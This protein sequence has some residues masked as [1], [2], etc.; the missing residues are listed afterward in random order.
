[1]AKK[2]LLLALALV[3]V[4][5]A[6]SCGD[7]DDSGGGPAPT[8]GSDQSTTTAQDEGEPVQGG[9]AMLLFWAEQASLDPVRSN[10][11]S[12]STGL[13][14]F[15]LYGALVATDPETL[16]VENVLAES[17]EPN[18]TFDTWTLKIRS[19]V[20]FSD[21]STYNA[22]AVRAHWARIQVPENRSSA[23]AF[24]STVASA[25]PVDELTLEIKL[26]EPNSLFDRL[27]ARS[28]MNYIPSAEA[29]ASGHDLTSDP[30]GAGPFLLDS[31]IRDDRMVLVRNPDWYDA[32]RPYLDKITIRVVTDEE[33]RL[34]TLLTGDAD[35]NYT[36]VAGSVARA[37][38][39][40]AQYEGVEVAFGSTINFNVTK[41]PFDDPELRRAIV[42]AVDR[43][44]MIEAA[45]G[46][47]A[48]APDNF[49]I[50]GTPWYNPDATVPEYDPEQAQQIINDYLARTGQSEINVRMVTTQ[51]PR[52]IALGKFM[53]TSLDQLEGVNIQPEPGDQPTLLQKVFSLD[54]GLASWGFPTLLPDPDLYQGIS[55]TSSA[56]ATGYKSPEVDQL[57]VDARSTSDPDERAEIYSELFGIL[58]KDLPF[59][60]YHSS[61]GWV[62]NEG[63]H[64]GDLYQEGI[65]RTD[66]SWV[67]P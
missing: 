26:V 38:D 51:S 50:E 39:E 28:A 62:I 8:D 67:E 37:L 55:S 11:T 61:N 43:Q 32:P 44:A 41:P 20:T 17:F 49:T 23:L 65:I 64:I 10:P 33:Q 27:V 42:M 12:G 47:G 18:D 40:G 31:W 57:F 4:L 60:P 25:N 45:D 63:F 1:M 59:I 36:I 35:A 15:A 16:E 3:F 2:R 6:A 5:I 19:G 13:R 54:F 66:L 24:A 53:Q 48:V 14:D 58:A 46:A 52:N 56:N 30:V 7:D 22:E 21:G 34:D 29:V 9:E